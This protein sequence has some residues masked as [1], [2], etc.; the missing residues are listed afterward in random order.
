VG[1]GA[2]VPFGDRGIRVGRSGSSFHG[3]AIHEYSCE[4]PAVREKGIAIAGPTN[5]MVAIWG[6]SCESSEEEE[7]ELCRQHVCVS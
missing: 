3:G 7:P 1:L 5:Q 6:L 2:A 4:D